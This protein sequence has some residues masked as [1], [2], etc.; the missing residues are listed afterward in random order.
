M[1]DARC[2]NAIG[3]GTEL[4]AFDIDNAHG[5]KALQRVIE[6]ICGCSAAMPGVKVRLASCRLKLGYLTA[7]SKT[8]VL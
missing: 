5:E 6:D 8:H 7:V 2:R 1:P 3:A 4:K